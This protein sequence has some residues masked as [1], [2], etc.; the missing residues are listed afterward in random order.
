[1]R[2]SREQAAE[3]RARILTVAGRL[4]RERGF[5][6]VGVSDIMKAAG[7]THGGFYGHFA[8]KDDLAAEACAHTLARK[9]AIWPR[10]P[11]SMPRGPLAAIAESYL[12]TTHRDNPG[13]G[14]LFA[15]LGGDAARQPAPVR[16]AVAEGLRAYVG[17]LA[18]FMPGRSKA[19]RRE[20]ALAAMA[21]FVGALILS[22]AVDDK[23]FSEEI[24]NAAAKTIGGTVPAIAAGGL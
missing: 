5:D 10:L 3:N 23:D 2:V 19:A 21:G 13:K 16:H 15:S 17:K 24:L 1:M 14:C 18:R 8:S 20:R 4:F 6:G 22:R 11:E 9:A 12:T 7:L